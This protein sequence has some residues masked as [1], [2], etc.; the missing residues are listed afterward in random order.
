M[1]IPNASTLRSGPLS[2]RFVM[3][4]PYP[5]SDWRRLPSRSS[6]A[7]LASQIVDTRLF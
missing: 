6:V 5:R 3:T 7:M 2:Y 1:P 4:S